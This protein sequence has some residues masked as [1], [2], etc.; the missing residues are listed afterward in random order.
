MTIRQAF[1]VTDY[2]VIN[3]PGGVTFRA[4]PRPLKPGSGSFEPASEG[5][6]QAGLRLKAVRLA[7]GLSAEKL[8]EAIGI[9]RNALTA[10]ETGQNMADPLAMARL[11]RRFGVAMEWIYAGEIRNVRDFEFQELVLKHA[12]ELGAVVGAPFAE[13]PAQTDHSG[14]QPGRVPPKRRPAG[15]TV[16]EPQAPIDPDRPGRH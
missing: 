4:M 1:P 15:A 6:R 13:F 3:R 14:R 9:S 16:H 11:L 10:Y 8:A 12:A 2:D 7:I 5:K